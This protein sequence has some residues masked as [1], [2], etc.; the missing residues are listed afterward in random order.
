[1][2]FANVCPKAHIKLSFLKN[3]FSGIKKVLTIFSIFKKMFLK[4]D[5]LM[6]VLRAHINQIQIL[7]LGSLYFIHHRIQH[8]N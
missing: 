8:S 5:S 2:D 1:M 4:I 3:I 6:C 7:L